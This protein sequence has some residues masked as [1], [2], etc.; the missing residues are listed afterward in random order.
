MMLKVRRH[1]GDEWAWF[2]NIDHVEGHGTIGTDGSAGS[3]DEL[4]EAVEHQW[5]TERSFDVEVWPTWGG[6][7]GTDQGDGAAHRLYQL[8]TYTATRR[9]GT[10]LLAVVSGEAFLLSD[11][12]A[13]V[14]RL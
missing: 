11:T 6:V 14:D 8:R 3:F 7:N 10:S 9:D 1:Y 5:G 12:G 4:R 13:T 2:D